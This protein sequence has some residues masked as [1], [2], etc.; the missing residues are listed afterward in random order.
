[1]PH[2]ILEHSPDV[3]AQQISD[4]LDA[5]FAAASNHPEFPDPAAIKMRALP[6]VQQRMAGKVH[7][8]A[9][10]TIKLL[11]GRDTQTK[12]ALAQSMLSVLENHLPQVG[13]LTVDPRDM[14]SDT[15]A[16]RIL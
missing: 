4:T 3:S 15:Y 8:F 9:H 7:S 6:C 10:L 11:T 16:K 1:M 14:A 12:A 2:F 5:L 13:Q